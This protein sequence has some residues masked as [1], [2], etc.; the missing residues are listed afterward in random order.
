MPE[1]LTLSIDAMGGDNAPDMVIEGIQVA[2][3]KQ[4]DLKF[5]LFGDEEY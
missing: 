1:Q 4:P 5:L 3:K 2:L